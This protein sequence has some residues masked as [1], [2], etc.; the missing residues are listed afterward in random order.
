MALTPFALLAQKAVATPPLVT[1]E[2]VAVT[3]TNS[4][5][6]RGYIHNG[7]YTYKGIPYAQAKRFQAPEKPK[8]WDAFAARSSTDR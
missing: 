5:K 6:V 1:G 3:N 4:G 8:A 2:N 7:I